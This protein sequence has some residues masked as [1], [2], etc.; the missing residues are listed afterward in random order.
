[1]LNKCH[2]ET[3]HKLKF[4]SL[5][6]DVIQIKINNLKS[7]FNNQQNIFKFQYSQKNQK[8]IFLS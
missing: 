1:M 7:L 5:S 2:Y 6:S 4:H 3:E 8:L